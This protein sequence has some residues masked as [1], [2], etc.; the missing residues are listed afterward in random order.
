MIQDD[1]A[2]YLSDLWKKYG[3]EKIANAVL[4]DES[5]WGT[6]LTRLP[7]FEKDVTEKLSLISSGG[8]RAALQTVL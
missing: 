6:D 2:G 8:M 5:L 3:D 7:G 1:K 4:R